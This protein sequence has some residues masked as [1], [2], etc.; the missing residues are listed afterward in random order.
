MDFPLNISKI[1]IKTERL[2]LRPFGRFDLKDFYEYASVPGVGEMAGWPHHTSK[3][4]TK[5]VLRSFRESKEVFAIY[6]KADKKVIGSIGL[7]YAWINKVPKY[8]NLKAK[9]IGYVL[10]KNYWGQGLMVEAVKALIEY[11]FANFGIEA[12]SI[13][14]FEENAQSRRVIEKCGFTF[15]EKGKYYS[16]LLNKHFDDMRYILVK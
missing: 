14:H 7:H 10:S 15:V 11:G 4:T 1:K 5:I 6:H 3:K 12:F 8:R 2:L 13:E 9:N 16:Q